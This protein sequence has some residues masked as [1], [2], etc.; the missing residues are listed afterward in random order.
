MARGIKKV[1]VTRANM[2]KFLTE[3]DIDALVAKAYMHHRSISGT[4]LDTMAKL[5]AYESKQQY[6]DEEQER[7]SASVRA[8][9]L[10]YLESLNCHEEAK[11][12]EKSGELSSGKPRNRHR[13]RA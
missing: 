12:L 4:E 7:E 10:Y 8:R 1:K 3:Q 13:A 6:A 9:M 2:L 11:A 5:F